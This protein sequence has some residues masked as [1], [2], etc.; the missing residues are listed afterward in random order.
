MEYKI[1]K[2]EATDIGCACSII[3]KIGVENIMECFKSPELINY[4]NSLMKNKNTKQGEEVKLSDDELQKAGAFILPK[5][6]N[7]ILRKMEVAQDDVFRFVARLTDL[8]F[9]TVAHLSLSQFAK[10]FMQIVKD[11]EFGDFIS[12][13]LESFN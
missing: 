5:V 4:I 9:E 10:L 7:L 8:E 2:P 3:E 13:V 12:A 1:R 6:G 11:P